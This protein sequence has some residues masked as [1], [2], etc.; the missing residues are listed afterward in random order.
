MDGSSTT[1]D[2]VKDVMAL[3]HSTRR[4]SEECLFVM[5]VHSQFRADYCIKTPPTQRGGRNYHYFGL[6]RELARGIPETDG[7]NIIVEALALMTRSIFRA[8][9]MDELE[10]YATQSTVSSGLIVVRIS[11]TSMRVPA[12]LKR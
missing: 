3:I 4:I 10:G 2:A 6:G 7:P 8:K 11:T 1:V 9:A 5:R 12:T